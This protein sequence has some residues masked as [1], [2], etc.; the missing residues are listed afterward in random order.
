LIVKKGH[1]YLIRACSILKQQE[2]QFSCLIVG[3]GFLELTLGKLIKQLDLEQEVT[4]AGSHDQ[5]WV[6]DRLAESDLFVLPCIMDKKGGRDGIPV[7][8][9]EA[10][11]MGVPVISTPVSGIPE[12]IEN[13]T[14][15]LLVRERNV[16]DL[17]KAMIELLGDSA[18]RE[19]ISQNG[20]TRVRRDFDIR[21]NV[22]E[23]SSIFSEVANPN[24]PS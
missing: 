21:A 4:L 16:E 6:R 12:L 3:S 13:H 17:A 2:I 24:A 20:I 1:E 5:T 19:S 15:G 7:A 11:A 9:M 18:L 22:C 10:M 23:L 8:L 14:T